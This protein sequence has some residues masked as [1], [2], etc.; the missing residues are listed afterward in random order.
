MGHYFLDT[1]YRSDPFYIVI[2]YIKLVTTSWTHCITLDDY[3]VSKKIFSFNELEKR[4]Q[5]RILPKFH[6]IKIF[7]LVFSSYIKFKM[8]HTVLPLWSINTAKKSI[9]ILIRPYFVNQIRIRQNLKTGS[10]S[11]YDHILKTG[12]G[13]NLIKNLIRPKHPD[14]NP[15]P[16]KIS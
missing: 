12:S 1:Q 3:C 13:S 10:G 2:Y 15:Q 11:G 9:L 8:I 5:I 7:F 6:L 16:C 14:P 4:T